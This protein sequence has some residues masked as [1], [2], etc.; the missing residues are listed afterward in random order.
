MAAKLGI[1]EPTL[2]DIVKE[3]LKPGRDPRDE[4]PKPLMR[5]G[6][7][8]TAEDLIEGLRVYIRKG[9]VKICVPQLV[10]FIVA[11]HLIR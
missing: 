1:G 8:M 4:L 6:D 3:L 9:P 7:I 11:D 2:R 10:D 5:S